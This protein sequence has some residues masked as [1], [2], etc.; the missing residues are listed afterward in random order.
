MTVPL[1]PIHRIQGPALL[2]PLAGRDVSTRGVVI[3]ATRKGFFIQDPDGSPV[4]GASCGVFVFR[5]RE[6]PPV[7]SLVEVSGR[8]VDYLA[9]DLGRPSTQ[10]A[11]GTVT[12]VEP[13]GPELEPVWLNAENVLVEPERLAA[14]LNSLEGM[15]VGV[16]AGAV[17]AAPSNPFGDYVVLPDDADLKRTAHGGVLIDPQAP[18]RWLPGFRLLDYDRAPQVNV[19]SKLLD[20]VTGPLNFRVESFQIAARGP[21]RVER[22]AVAA[23]TTTLTDD[24]THLTVLTLNGFNLDPHVESA[25]LVKDPRRDI[26]DDVGDLRFDALGLAVASTAAAPT[27]VA[28]QEIQ[29]EDGAEMTDVVSARRTYE[30]LIAA[31]RDS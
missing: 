5:R 1:T 21:V 29:D 19:G 18:E 10:V 16:K 20:D 28:L 3:G 22:A 9:D 31:I 13:Y 6:K 8:V 11:A 25:N 23:A 26:D 27:I 15:L 4:S 17:F 30:S 14:F 24:A 7:G 2:S 12:M